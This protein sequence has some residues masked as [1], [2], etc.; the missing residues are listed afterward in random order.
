MGRRS[1]GSS[2]HADSERLNADKS[3]SKAFG[4]K[5]EK[6]LQCTALVGGCGLGPQAGG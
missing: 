6:T 2:T 4:D 3:G 5:K 1:G